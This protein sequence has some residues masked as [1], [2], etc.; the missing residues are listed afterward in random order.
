M[1]VALGGDRNGYRVGTSSTSSTPS[2]SRMPV[3]KVAWFI[4]VVLG[5]TAVSSILASVLG[6]QAILLAVV[7]TIFTGA[8]GFWAANLQGRERARALERHQAAESQRRRKQEEYR[9][10]STRQGL[11]HDCAELLRR[12]E[13]AVKAILESDARAGDLLDPPVDEK[14]LRDCVHRIL[15]AGAKVTDLRARQRKIAINSLPKSDQPNRGYARDERT[16]GP[17]TGAVLEPQQQALAMVLRSMTT[18]AENLEQYAS[19]I[20]KVDATYRDWIGSQE[21]GRLNDSVRDVLAEMVR[22]KLAAEEL[23]RLAERTSLAEQAFRQSIQEA[24]LAAETLALP[25]A[26]DSPDSP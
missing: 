3:N 2:L 19:S 26:D 25:E 17:M 1:T 8:A 11:D 5:L 21:A 22:D 12:A 15:S 9:Q 7:S 23:S 20:K 14:L 6:A 18:H 4:V 13:T 10:W 16:P 24:S